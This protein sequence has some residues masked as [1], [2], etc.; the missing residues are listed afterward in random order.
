[1]CR[2]L[3]SG[4][5]RLFLGLGLRGRSETGPVVPA[6]PRFDALVKKIGIPWRE[7]T[8]VRQGRRE[9]DSV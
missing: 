7:R 3:A 9:P 1:V 5:P 2:L 4:L 8:R 6:D